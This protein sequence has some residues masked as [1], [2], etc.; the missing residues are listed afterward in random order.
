MRNFHGRPTVAEVRLAALRGNLRAARELVGPD[1]A[2]CAVVKA[3]GYGHGAVAAARAFVEA[4][5]AMLGVSTVQEGVEI[6]EAGVT[7][8]I[9][10]LGGVFP[11]EAAAVVAHGLEAA[12]WTKEVVQTLVDAARAAATT[13]PVHVKVDT[14]M[15]R[16]GLDREDVRAFG[17]TLRSLPE[18]RV[19]GIFSHFASADAVETAEAALQLE[20]F[21]GAVADLAAAGIRP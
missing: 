3:D 8:P 6:R 21:R 20:R 1:V 13:V 11:G 2:V 4:G 10:V 17:E 16:L 15:T 18:I 12:V 7:A 5:A 19:E 9:V 14:G